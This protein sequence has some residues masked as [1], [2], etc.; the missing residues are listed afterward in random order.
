[1]WHDVARCGAMWRNVAQCGTMWRNVA[2][3]GVMWLNVVWCGAMW[4]NVA[5]CGAMSRNMAWCGTQWI[6]IV[7]LLRLFEQECFSEISPKFLLK[8]CGT[9][10]FLFL[11]KKMLPGTET[12][13]RRVSS[14]HLHRDWIL[15][16]ISLSQDMAKT[17]IKL[18]LCTECGAENL[19][20]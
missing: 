13:A 2:Q 19:D 7:F 9:L 1:M 18:R 15:V 17:Q 12:M 6:L 4:G 20:F 3:C 16:K 8:K 14:W 10:F 5:Q 11:A